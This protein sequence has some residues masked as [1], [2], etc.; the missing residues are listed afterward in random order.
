MDG[1]YSMISVKSGGIE[2]N[3]RQ[4][5]VINHCKTLD[6]DF[7]ILQ[8]THVTFSHLHEV[9]ILPGKTQTCHAPPI[10]QIITD[11]ARGYVFFK[12]ENTADVASVLYAPKCCLYEKLSNYCIKRLP[13]KINTL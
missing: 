13:T 6:M 11:P 12:I 4:D 10:K 2:E 7:S 1:T 5:L 3:K 8:E 9:I